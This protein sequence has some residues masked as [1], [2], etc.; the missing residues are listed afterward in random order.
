MTDKV[1]PF[2][3]AKRLTPEEIALKH[4]WV[5]EKRHFSESEVKKLV[6]IAL[7]TMNEVDQYS[8]MDAELDLPVKSPSYGWVEQFLGVFEERLTL[9]KV[10]DV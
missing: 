7:Q 5:R 2:P 10:C 6:F 4:K 1:I 3:V 9:E 8:D